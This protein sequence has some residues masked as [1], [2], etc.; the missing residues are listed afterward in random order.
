MVCIYCGNKTDVINSRPQKRYNK[1]WRR[2]HCEAC[3]ATFTSIEAAAL[4]EG[5]VIASKGPKPTYRPFLRDK[6]FLSV[7]NSCQHRT[8]AVADAT[9]LTD[10]ILG[11]LPSISTNGLVDRVSLRKS[12]LLVLERFDT[13]AAVHYAAFHKD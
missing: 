11:K 7:Y 6:L 9:A 4:S 13:S 12:T 1:V 5:L 10:T 3:G 8:T 2:R